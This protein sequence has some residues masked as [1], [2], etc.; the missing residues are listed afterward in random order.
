M[1]FEFLGSKSQSPSLIQFYNT[2]INAIKDYISIYLYLLI[3]VNSLFGCE[4]P[5]ICALDGFL[6]PILVLCPAN[7]LQKLAQ[8]LKGGVNEGNGSE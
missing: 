3:F 4:N 7:K 5:G 1:Q 8:G 2:Q 6:K